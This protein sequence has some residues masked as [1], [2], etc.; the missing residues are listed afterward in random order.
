MSQQVALE[1][2]L[3]ESFNLVKFVFYKVLEEMYR[4][5]LW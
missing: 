2:A 3:A 5:N 1:A 4:P